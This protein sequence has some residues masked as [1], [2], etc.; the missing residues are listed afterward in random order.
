ML[1]LRA[2]LMALS[3]AVLVSACSSPVA[4]PVESSAASSPTPTQTS[5]EEVE[6]AQ[7]EPLIDLDCDDFAPI[8]EIGTIAGVPER[9]PRTASFDLFES[10]P[11][12]DVVRNAGGLACEFSDGGSWVTDTSEG[13]AIN[14]SWH[15]A[16]VYV[17]PNAAGAEATVSPIS[18]CGDSSTNARFTV[19]SFHFTA[20]GA[21][22]HIVVSTNDKRE[23]IFAIRDFVTATVAAAA[24]TPGPIERAPGTFAPPPDC[25]ALI[26][27]ATVLG[28]SDITVNYAIELGS[29]AEASYYTENIGCEYFSESKAHVVEVLVYPGGAWAAELNLPTLVGSP[30]AF[31]DLEG[32]VHCTAVPDWGFTMCTVEVVVDGT[33]VRA[34]GN[35]ATEAEST[36]IAVAAATA[37]LLHR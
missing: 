8:A 1:V 15:G 37:V 29:E 4:P 19:C 26:D 34:I 28:A 20:G 22:V 16:A 35:T 36:A 3:I 18:T 33:W 14:E 6:S 24:S 7:P 10:V 32:L 30:V 2:S 27:A 12:A 13:R 25:A 21:W 9:D 23:T 17:V 31:A 11:V 5:S